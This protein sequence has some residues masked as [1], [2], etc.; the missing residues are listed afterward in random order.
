MRK[1]AQRITSLS[2]N[3]KRLEGICTFL[4]PQCLISRNNTK[5]AEDVCC[6]KGYGTSP[7]DQRLPRETYFQALQHGVTFINVTS[8]FTLNKRSRMLPCPEEGV[9]FSGLRGVWDGPHRK[10]CRVLQSKDEKDHPDCHQQQEPP[11]RP[12]LFLGRPCMFQQ[13]NAK[14]HSAYMTAAWLRKKRGWVS[15]QPASL[16]MLH[17]DPILLHTWGRVC[18]KNYTWN[19]SLPDYLLSVVGKK[20]WQ[21]KVV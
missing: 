15:D 19:S 11:S 6:I 4:P 13:D 5:A 16:N 20:Q 18:G 14:P 21:H 12:H 8:N 10:R 7:L 9:Y 1:D 3:W 17:C 2:P